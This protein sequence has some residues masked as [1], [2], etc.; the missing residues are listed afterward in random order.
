MDST[1]EDE[2]VGRAGHHEAPAQQQ[3]KDETAIKPSKEAT[4]SADGSN[5]NNNKNVN[6]N[7]TIGYPQ[8]A[9]SYAQRRTRAGTGS[10]PAKSRNASLARKMSVG[11]PPGQTPNQT[12]QPK[13][14]GTGNMVFGTFNES[15]VRAVCN[16]EAAPLVHSVSHLEHRLGEAVTRNELEALRLQLAEI[17]A[18]HDF[19]ARQQNEDD[20]LAT[21]VRVLRADLNRVME[22]GVKPN[23]TATAAESQKNY[24]RT[25]ADDVNKDEVFVL[26]EPSPLDKLPS[27][28][29]T[30]S[31]YQLGSRRSTRPKPK[32]NS[33]SRVTS[34]RGTR[35]SRYELDTSS[36]SDVEDEESNDQSSEEEESV[37]PFFE[38]PKGPRFRNMEVIRPSDELF[39][40]LMNY[41]Y[42]RLK[43]PDNS[44]TSTQTGNVHRLI[45]S[46][47][48]SMSEFKF[49]GTD[50]ILVFD[51][52]TRMVE[53]AD[54]LKMT[55]AQAYLALPHY[56]SGQASRTYR[57]SR[58]GA[59]S[60]GVSCWPEA[61]QYLLR[62]YATASAIREA[63]S[64]VRNTRQKHGENEA[65]Y[66]TRINHAV[67]RCGN[68]F[69][70]SEKMSMFVNGLSLKI[71]P[72]VSRFREANHRQGLTYEELVQYAMDEGDANRARMTDIRVVKPKITTRGVHFVDIADSTE[73]VNSEN[74]EHVMVLPEES[75][76]TYELPSTA[77]QQSAS[78]SN[79]YD[80]LPVEEQLM[81]AG[82]ARHVPPTAIP[83]GDKKTIP[84]RV[85]WIKREPAKDIICFQCYEENDHISPKCTV[86]VNELWKVVDNY[87]NLTPEQKSRVPDTA[88]HAAKG[89]LR[90]KEE[91][92]KAGEERADRASAGSKN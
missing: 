25:A 14:S 12:N 72:L 46:M 78:V 15:A 22:C 35:K 85:G 9:L 24:Q 55:E 26:E 75:I 70:E 16:T 19:P 79:A 8:A 60:G 10:L 62:T 44:R 54:T 6:T 68:V 43:S 86:T 87:E 48:L 2:E 92:R 4:R 67:Y 88:Y 36:D 58:N 1:G 71:Q 17:K 80:D 18:A 34:R 33:H 37:I 27:R 82:Q 11:N 57:S 63:V 21:H 76:P 39:K 51:F 69:D 64:T 32:T 59:H 50:P 31:N 38:R 5:N 84:T 81:Y 90:V 49:D 73:N 89:Y 40:R 20:D 3:T 30:A 66:S 29:A 74:T 65:E 52:L 91:A 41:R 53:E 7:P 23:Q 47:N 13:C 83:Y 56:L 77:S 28:Q 61:V 45:K 42:Y